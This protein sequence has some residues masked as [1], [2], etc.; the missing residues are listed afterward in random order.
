VNLAFAVSL[1]G[2]F[3]INI[4]LFADAVSR[5]A[6]EAWNV[7]LP[8]VGLAILASVCM[9]ATALVGFKA[10]NILATLLVPIL[11]IVTVLFTQSALSVQ[12]LSEIMAADRAAQ[13]TIGQGISAIVGAIIYY[14]T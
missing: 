13:I 12:S 9:T 2:W 8:P 1:L 3:G 7:S 5:L 14:S 11:A 4:N 6:F 10:I